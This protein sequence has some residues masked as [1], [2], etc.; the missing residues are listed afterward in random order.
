MEMID[1][2]WLVFLLKHV[3]RATLTLMQECRKQAEEYMKKHNFDIDEGNSMQ[4][5]LEEDIEFIPMSEGTGWRI[6]AK[7]SPAVV[8]L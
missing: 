8:R 7:V 6:T 4:V 2:T 5:T 3:C 1:Y